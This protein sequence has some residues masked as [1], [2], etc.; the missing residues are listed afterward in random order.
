[1][2]FVLNLDDERGDGNVYWRIRHPSL[3]M[4]RE[5]SA[6]LAFT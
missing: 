5:I 6:P 3:M 4:G 1:L 2:A